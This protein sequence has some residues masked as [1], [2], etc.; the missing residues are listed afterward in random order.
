MSYRFSWKGGTY[1]QKSTEVYKFYL[2]AMLEEEELIYFD[3]K[4]KGVFYDAPIEDGTAELISV[5]PEVK[6]FMAQQGFGLRKS[7]YSF[8]FRF[9]RIGGKVIT[10]KPFGPNPDSYMF[11]GRGRFMDSDEIKDRVG[12]DSKTYSY[13]TYQAYLSK[14]ELRRHVMVETESTVG[15]VG[16]VRMLRI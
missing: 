9:E 10:I 4:R 13:Y 16:Q 11:R 12:A 1:K 5:V 3:A 7:Y 15:E 6:V 2:F 14:A 8:F